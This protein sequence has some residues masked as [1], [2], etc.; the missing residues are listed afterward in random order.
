M[1]VRDSS[2]KKSNKNSN[3]L[4]P[5]PE[6]IDTD[7]SAKIAMAKRVKEDATKARRGKSVAFKTHLFGSS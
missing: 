3:D 7:W 5:A 2:S 4:I 6:G 1:A